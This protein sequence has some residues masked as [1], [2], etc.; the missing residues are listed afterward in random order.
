MS[1][2]TRAFDPAAYLDSESAAIAYVN[3]ALETGDA[4]F[5]ADALSVVARSRGVAEVAERAGLSRESLHR[6][7]SATGNLDFATVLKVARAL[8]I[9]FEA[10]GCAATSAGGP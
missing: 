5:I 8:G 1:G 10:T 4:A 6:S 9:R 3:E 7:L 2:E